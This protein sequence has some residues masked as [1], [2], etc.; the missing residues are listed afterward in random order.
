MSR[1]VYAVLLSC[2]TL[3]RLTVAVHEK[4]EDKLMP[5]CFRIDADF[6][7]FCLGLGTNKTLQQNSKVFVTNVVFAWKEA[8]KGNEMT[9]SIGS[10]PP[11][12]IKAFAVGAGTASKRRK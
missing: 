8:V 12:F 11:T 4:V 3:E 10:I 5:V 9:S 6:A 2:K 1:R 7:A